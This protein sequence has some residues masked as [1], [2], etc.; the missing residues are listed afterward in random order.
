M[1]TDPA[2]AGAA[3]PVER[4]ELPWYRQPGQ[5]ALLLFGLL[6]I[7]GLIIL[8]IVLTSG[9]DDEDGAIVDDGDAPVSLVVTRLDAQGAP[10][11]ASITAVVNATGPAP[12]QYAWVVPAEAVTGEPAIRQTDAGGRSEF[13]WQ[14][15]LGSDL[16]NWSSTVEI[17]EVVNG[18]LATGGVSSECRI[19]RG[20]GAP[21]ALA[22]TVAFAGD[23]IE[24]DS[25][26]IATYAFP[27]VTFA[28]GDRIECT[29]TNGT[30]IVAAVP[31]DP[32]TTVVD[33]TT[34]VPEETT[35]TIIETT[36][37][38]APETT[39]TT[40]V[41][42]TTTTT[43]APETTTTTTL[44]PETTTTT[45]E[46]PPPPTLPRP[47][48]NPGSALEFLD[49]RG[50]LSAFVDII[51]LAGL[52]DE[53][54]DPDRRFTLFVPNNDAISAI[55]N[56]PNGPDR[57][58]P[59]VLRNIVR[60]HV[61]D[62]DAIVEDQIRLRDAMGVQFG[63]PQPVVEGPPLTVGGAT[64]LEVN[65]VTTQSIIHVIDRVLPADY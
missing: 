36:T 58:D 54:N 30:D 52:V 53:F 40:V 42:E 21:T 16:D 49:S 10:F 8:L 12:E 60:T 14:P 7:A 43:L 20:D 22:T 13:R 63:D 45:T 23:G 65:T 27:N 5:L 15:A 50:D 48:T 55:V 56:D 39:T 32:T 64:V 33:T 35:T 31:V 59:E 26:A 62:G 47:D 28:A 6:A 34:T 11:N 61:V 38:L 9:D 24:A 29:F 18:Q 2:A 4:Y 1:P 17:G 25:P 51:Q 41:P 57:S 37:T 19:D 44:A 46:P 3:Q